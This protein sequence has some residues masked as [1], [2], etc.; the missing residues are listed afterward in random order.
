MNGIY[1]RFVPAVK[2][3][4]V[5]ADVQPTMS[6]KQYNLYLSTTATGKPWLLVYILKEVVSYESIRIVSKRKK[7]K[8][9]KNHDQ[10]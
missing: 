4:S 8:E 3:K 9:V 1:V 6:E 5:A 7:N 2:S 10:F